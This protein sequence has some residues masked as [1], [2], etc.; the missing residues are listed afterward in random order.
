MSDEK[1]LSRAKRELLLAAERLF[2]ARGIE[3]VSLREIAEAAGSRNNNAVQY[4][5]AGREGLMAAIYAMRVADMEDARQTMLAKAEAEGR[6]GDSL[7]LLQILCLPHLALR[8]EDGSHPYAGFL[9]HYVM[10]HWQAP[11][12]ELGAAG[13]GPA[14]QK[15]LR[16]IA[17]TLG[18]VPPALARSRSMLALLLFLNAL[19]RWDHI[20][21]NR[22]GLTAATMLGDALYSAHAALRQSPSGEGP[23]FFA[24]M[25]ES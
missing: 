5:F 8:A 14:Q 7:V 15:V 20:D 16:L 12:S 10:R 23:L 18:D 1:P 4:H 21:R 22:E 24:A 3:A 2:A 25:L 11:A 9:A 19:L 13:V 6:L 17:A